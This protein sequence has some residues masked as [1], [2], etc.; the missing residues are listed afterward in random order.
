[1][2]FIH[3]EKL[4]STLIDSMEAY[5][6]FLTQHYPGSRIVVHNDFAEAGHANDSQHYMGRA[7]DFHVEGCAWPEAWL[8]LERFTSITGIGF[9][10]YWKYNGKSMP[11]FHADTRSPVPYRARWVRNEAG[12]YIGFNSATFIEGG[13][14][15]SSKT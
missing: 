4:D 10:P 9:Y 12:G 5:E 6:K 14:L 8:A 13:G 7:V 11:G 3:R 15:R 2:N 1:M